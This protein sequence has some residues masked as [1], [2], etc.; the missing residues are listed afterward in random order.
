MGSFHDELL[1]A[2]A[3]RAMILD[4]YSMGEPAADCMAC[5]AKAMMAAA[6]IAAGVA[7]LALRGKFKGAG[8]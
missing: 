8:S 4:R 1:A 6:V 5:R 3:R 2:S 7:L